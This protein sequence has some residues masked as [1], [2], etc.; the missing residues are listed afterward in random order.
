METKQP[1]EAQ[2][3]EFWKRNSQL[4]I[5]SETQNC[6]FVLFEDGVRTSIGTSLDLNNLFKYAVPKAREKIGADE[7]ANRMAGWVNDV[8]LC[9]ENPEA[10]LFSLLRE[11]IKDG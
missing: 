9:G 7:L 8:I 10:S 6:W 3:R 2:L 11:A 4:I 1:T 5:F